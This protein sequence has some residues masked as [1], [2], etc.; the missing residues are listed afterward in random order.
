MS[1]CMHVCMYACMHLDTLLHLQVTLK[2]M[3]VCIYVFTLAGHPE[4]S[5]S[6]VGA[7]WQEVLPRHTGTPHSDFSDFLILP[8]RCS[9]CLNTKVLVCSMNECC[10][11]VH[12]ISDFLILHSQCSV[13]L[14]TKVLMY[15]TA[16]Y[17]YEV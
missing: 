2:C 16:Q 3:Y 12:L 11:G 10:R 17:A 13:C 15:S 14:N 4:A 6:Q 1:A 9:V 8:S 7:F 5:A